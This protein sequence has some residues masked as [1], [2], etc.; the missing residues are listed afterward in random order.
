MLLGDRFIT[1]PCL[2]SLVW[3]RALFHSGR[4]RDDFLAR[5]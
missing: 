5:C 4:G 1:V 3:L 2:Y